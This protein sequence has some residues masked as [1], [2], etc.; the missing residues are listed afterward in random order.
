MHKGTA[1]GRMIIQITDITA[2]RCCNLVFKTLGGRFSPCFMLKRE[3]N[4]AVVFMGKLAS[5]EL[6][7]F[8]NAR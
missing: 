5:S 2:C 4:I 8:R 3:F 1:E 7:W 6:I